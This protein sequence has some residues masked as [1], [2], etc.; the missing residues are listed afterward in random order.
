MISSSIELR[1]AYFEGTPTGG[2]ISTP[3]G[4]VEYGDDWLHTDTW[5][6][7]DR[8]IQGAK[9]MNSAIAGMALFAPE[10]LSKKC[11]DLENISI[12]P[13]SDGSRK[14]TMNEIIN[15]MRNDLETGKLLIPVDLDWD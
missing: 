5:K 14:A 4:W 12:K 1:E 7:T 10:T 6:K 11:F 8:Y 15:M 3:A 9:E 13:K 2:Y